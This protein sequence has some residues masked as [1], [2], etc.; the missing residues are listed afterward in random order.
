MTT[1]ELEARA[2][3]RRAEE[4]FRKA[5]GGVTR[6]LWVLEDP[7]WGQKFLTREQ[8]DAMRRELH[9][10]GLRFYRDFT[11]PASDDPACLCETARAYEHMAGVYAVQKEYAQVVECLR[12]AADVLDRLAEDFPDEPV[13]REG[14]GR[15]LAQKGAWHD[16]LGHT[17]GRP[18]EAR[19]SDARKADAAFAGALA[20][21]RRVL[22]GD[23]DGRLHNRLAA[24]LAACPVPRLR[25]PAAAVALARE[26]LARD[27]RQGD[28]WNSLGAAYYRCGE[29]GEAA[30]ALGRSMELRA[31][32]DA[33]DWLLMAMAAWRWGDREQ[34]RSWHDRAAAWMEKNV[35]MSEEH[36][37]LR[38]EADELLGLAGPL[39]GDG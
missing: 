29:Y 6:L 25:D 14:Q 22:P 3:R 30:A 11:H 13:Y 28:Y 2:Q 27:P 15:V 21:Y 37:R 5:L 1:Q 18:E 31:G 12:R 33:S 24:L 20:A 26:A 16:T 36:S 19:R 38:A 35:A 23:A 39:P 10:Q 32:G 34:A 17:P 9:T 8:V 7:R 4:S